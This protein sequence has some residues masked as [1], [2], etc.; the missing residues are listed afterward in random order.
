[1]DKGELKQSGILHRG[2]PERLLR[3]MEKAG[4]GEPLT[5]GFIGGSITQGALADTEE[6]CWAYRVYDWWKRS[7]PKA[8][9]VYVN[10][11][12]GGTSSHFGAARVKED[13]LERDPDVV[14]VE[15]SV[16]D[17]NTE[18]FKETYEGLVRRI[19][20]NERK[21][22]LLLIHN[23]YYDSG[24]SAEQIHSCIGLHYDLTCI[25]MKQAIYTQIREGSLKA[26]ELT[27][28][29]L[30]PNNRGHELVA[31]VIEEYLD[32]IRGAFR[33][34]PEVE[35]EARQS[36]EAQKE[37]GLP[38]PL[39]KNA[40]ETALCL[41]NRRC[42]PVLEGFRKDERAK[43]NLRDLFKEGWTGSRLGDRFTLWVEG[44][45]IALQYRRSV[46]GWGPKAMA[47]VDDH[48]ESGV[49]LDG[50]FDETWGDK[51]E[52]TCILSG[53]AYGRHKVEVTICR[54]NDRDE[55]QFYLTAV[56]AA[57]REGGKGKI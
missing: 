47:V 17:E 18:H 36:R 49:I 39:T 21:P 10:A 31:R 41:T 22:A 56:L 13:I 54:E 12:I 9:P 46:T 6:L 50:G 5:I 35:K 30:H 43:A 44:S 40:Y 33:Q 24:R 14:F 57:G 26:Q 7:F 38:L 11:G 52:L 25:S 3:A 42:S 15:F 37:A 34:Q 19:Y 27:Q 51:L 48:R 45:E 23:M 32:E 53:G 20:A 16:N 1:M 29:G 8:E 55:T 2:S 4:K 28:D